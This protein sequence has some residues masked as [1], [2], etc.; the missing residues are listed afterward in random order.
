[1][2]KSLLP[3]ALMKLTLLLAFTWGVMSAA[4]AADRLYISRTYMKP[5]ET[6]TLAINLENEVPY[7]GFQVDISLSQGL[8]FATENS[9]H[10]IFLSPRADSSYSLVTNTWYSNKLRVGAFSCNH[11]PIAD[12]SGALLFVKVTADDEFDGGVLILSDI[13]FAGENDKNIVLPE[14]FLYIR[15]EAYNKCYLP[16]FS[17]AIDQTKTMSLILDS[18]TPFAA[19]QTDVY[20]PEGV[21]IVADSFKT[22]PRTTNHTISTKSFSDGRTRIICFSPDN[23]IITAGEGPLIEFD[24]HADSDADIEK[25]FCTIELK[26]KTFSTSTAEEYV[27][28]DSETDVIFSGYLYN[29]EM[30]IGETLEL[31]ADI[32]PSYD[33]N[34][35]IEWISSNPEVATVSPSG[36]FTAVITAVGEG[37]AIITTRTT[38]GLWV[39]DD[40]VVNVRKDSYNGMGAITTDDVYITTTTDN[41]IIIH[42]LK[43]GV[44]AHL[45]TLNGVLLNSAVGNGSDIILDIIPNTHYI[46]KIGNQSLKLRS[47]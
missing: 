3:H 2:K 5:G 35:E 11:T 17:I 30:N 34:N 41:R 1:M 18:D 12:T 20:L 15:N 9:A 29:A 42:E 7:T 47:K 6:K 10:S 36:A 16:D 14:F 28:A 44:T 26:N 37:V 40:W 39:A 43:T 46:L 45:Y 19:F 32:D 4:T 13:N 8:K 38:D 27:L 31:I 24:I 25:G 33:T 23:S 21:S 22:T